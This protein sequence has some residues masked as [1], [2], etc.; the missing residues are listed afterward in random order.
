MKKIIT[1][2]IFAASVASL[3]ATSAMAGGFGRGSADIGMLL[4]PGNS[5]YGSATYVNP[6]R[7][8]QN[9]IDIADSFVYLGAGAA[10]AVGPAKCGVTLAQPYGANS[11]ETA[12]ALAV[13]D[14]QKDTISSYEFG[15][16]CAVGFD[17]GPVK[18]FGIA[19]LFGQQVDYE[20]EY[21]LA[22]LSTIVPELKLSDT[23]LGYRLGIGVAKPEIAL[24]ASLIYRSKVEHDLTGTFTTPVPL[25][26]VTSGPATASI[27]TPQSLK[28]SVQTGVAPKWVVFGSVEWTDWSVIQ[29]T[30]VL[31]NGG[32]AAAL[33][34]GFEDGWTVS[35]GVGH[36]LTDKLS[37]L[38]SITWDKGVSGPS[39]AAGGQNISAFFDSWTFSAGASYKLNDTFSIRAG[40]GYTT[41]AGGS[42][43]EDPRTAPNLVTYGKAHA[44]SGALSFNIKF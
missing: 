5:V 14:A 38:G 32:P 9:G 34:S 24:K 17:V 7:K 25:G 11:N 2:G 40:G 43:L 13:G 31:V 1:T 27:E 3:T 26:G 35:A 15:A 36:A 28:L 19:G 6:T 10:A 42:F 44:I 22:P 21:N 16:T 29:I 18:V 41:I 12:T 20:R 4:D 39:A 23:G 8:N 37:L 30:P 33:F